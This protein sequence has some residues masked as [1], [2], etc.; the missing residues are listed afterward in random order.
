MFR[1]EPGPKRRL[2]RGR[3]SWRDAQ[4]L[5]DREESDGDGIRDRDSGDQRAGF[6]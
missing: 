3:R 5:K 6:R 2:K 1:C 4:P